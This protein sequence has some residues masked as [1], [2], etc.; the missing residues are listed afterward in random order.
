MKL[1]TNISSLKVL[2]NT[3]KNDTRIEKSLE[4]LSSGLKINKASDDATGLAISRKMQVQIDAL[5]KA[6][7]KASDGISLIQTAE[8]ALN[9]VHSILQRMKELS[10][11][12]A[13]GTLSDED[14]T[15]VQSEITML[16]DEI[17]RISTTIQFNSMNLLDGSISNKTYPS[18]PQIGEVITLSDGVSAGSYKYE[19]TR[20][21][22]KTS[23]ISEDINKNIV[24]D[25]GYLT[26]DGTIYINGAEVKLST[27]MTELEAIEAMRDAA[28]KSDIT[29]TTSTGKLVD[30]NSDGDNVAK[31]IMQSN[32]SGQKD[33]KVSG[34]DNLMYL[35][36]LNHITEG[37]TATTHHEVPQ[38]TLE[39]DMTTYKDQTIRING[40]DILISEEEKTFEDVLNKIKKADI[41]GIQ[42]AKTS[43]G[44][45]FDSA[46]LEIAG[47]DTLVNEF[48][49]ALGTGTVDADGTKLLNGTVGIDVDARVES[50][51][52]PTNGKV[53][54][55]PQG[56]TASFEGDYIVFTGP[57]GFKMQIENKGQVGICE[58]I[59]TNAGALDLQIGANEGQSM[60]IRIPNM[61][62]KAIGIENLNVKTQKMSE[63]AI[64]KVDKAIERVSE[65]R[66]KLGAFNNRIEYTINSLTETQQNL[67]E[68]L[69]RIQDTDMAEEMAEYTQADILSQ[70]GVTI[71]AQAN[72]RPQGLLQLLQNMI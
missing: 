13:N 68:S 33:I 60:T 24:D 4:K 51:D 58:T 46:F 56:T 17:D 52:D 41:S 45:D 22:T 18:D 29:F 48:K 1:N 12:S 53:L 40:M 15:S 6:S 32:I 31:I 30:L 38:T 9:E 34:D 55:F 35:L 27:K 10:V 39:L 65:V 2:S 61:S 70:A 8:G 69:S 59:I 21:A 57:N 64:V 72:Q 20:L 28:E 26:F 37:T 47:P 54:G 62:A 43:A 44:W 66:A 71:L 23:R 11:Q 67:T 16:S 3:K 63:E 50:W 49:T 19:V 36:G 42:L 5:D 25:R 14:R 7:D